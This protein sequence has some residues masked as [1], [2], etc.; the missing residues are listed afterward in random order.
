VAVEAMARGRPVI[1]SDTGDLPAA[2]V[3]GEC[4]FIVPVGDVAALAARAGTLLDD[5]ALRARMGEAGRA[6]AVAVYSAGAMARR[7]EH[8][9]AALAAGAPGHAG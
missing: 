3:D 5:P 2:V 7:L 4:G 1:A 8:E 9:Y 6:R